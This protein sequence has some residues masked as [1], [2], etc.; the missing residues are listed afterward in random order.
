MRPALEPPHRS[1]PSARRLVRGALWSDAL[2]RALAELR[3]RHP[4]AGLE[5]SAV[6]RALA[7]A[8]RALELE[9]E[10]ARAAQTGEDG[11]GG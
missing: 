6:E 9:L 8:A 1:P 5:V 11:P 3:A 7:D 4:T 10:A 2:V